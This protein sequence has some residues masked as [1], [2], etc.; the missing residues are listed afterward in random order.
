MTFTYLYDTSRTVGPANEAAQAK[1]AITR[2]ATGEGR[3]V[4]S[5]T[6]HPHAT[7]HNPTKQIMYHL[8]WCTRDESTVSNL[9]LIAAAAVAAAVAYQQNAS[10]TVLASSPS[11]GGFTSL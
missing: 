1:P 10:V 2:S 8:G 4:E 7:T 3:K 5:S 6:Q 11:R 9:M